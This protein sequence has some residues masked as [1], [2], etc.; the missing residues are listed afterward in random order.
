M[1][2]I[3]ELE[4]NDMN[5][6]EL[7]SAGHKSEGLDEKFRLLAESQYYWEMFKDKGGKVIYVS[8]AF[9]RITGYKV[10][11]YMSG[12]VSFND[13][14]HP[15]DMKKAKDFSAK[16]LLRE[17][18]NDIELKMI[19]KNGETT[20]VSLL[21][22]PVITGSKEFIGFRSSIRDITDRKKIEEEF[23]TANIELETQVKKL[24]IELG[25]ANELLAKHK[26]DAQKTLRNIRED[27]EKR[28]RGQLTEL[29]SKNEALQAEIGKDKKANK[30]LETAYAELEAML[31]E[32]IVELDQAKELLARR[33]K[34]EE[35]LR[36][37][38]KAL[39]VQLKIRSSELAKSNELLAEHKKKERAAHK[40]HTHL[41]SQL[42]EISA[43][44][45][46]IE[47]MYPRLKKAKKEARQERKENR[48]L[49]LELQKAYR[50]LKEAHNELLRRDKKKIKPGSLVAGIVRE[51]KDPLYAIFHD[52]ETLHGKFKM[53]DP[54]REVAGDIIKK[55]K[56]FEGKIDELS[57]YGRK[58][59]LN[60]RRYNLI[61]CLN[62]NLAIM[63]PICRVRRVKVNKQ[64]SPLPSMEIDDEKINQAL[65]YV[66]E[67]AIQAM[68]KG[69]ILSAY[70]G[71]DEPAKAAVIKIHNTG[72]LV[73]RNRLKENRLD[74]GLTIARRIISKHGGRIKI[75][76]KVS[77]RNKGGAFIIRLPLQHQ[78][79]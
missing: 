67:N 7:R 5:A 6:S 48:K 42:K 14:I 39:E 52:L 20:H 19:R 65:H 59:N 11:D 32:K 53:G 18:F 23:K 62:T 73:G 75:E 21:S 8:P 78:K 33:K 64:Y 28:F 15:D 63:R 57:N 69:G 47:R 10:E 46:E 45:A 49:S 37:S 27:S 38:H 17:T 51:A 79:V 43:R 26:E 68:P 58:I 35:L 55:I 24:T 41:E 50:K 12:K 29:L 13:L 44:A 30:D 56:K 16:I 25:K 66:M 77:G 40:D 9:E 76:N 70:A 4:K 61:R 71:L 72:P 3:N 2:K 22:H 74:I 31:K 36:R 34:E 1:D 54:K 60:L